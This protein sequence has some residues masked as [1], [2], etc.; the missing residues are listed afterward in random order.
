[1]LRRHHHRA[2]RFTT[3]G[4]FFDTS[5]KTFAMLTP[6]SPSRLPVS[7]R[8][9]IRVALCAC[10]LA[11]FAPPALAVKDGDKVMVI[12]NVDLTDEGRKI[13]RPTPEQP[14]YY[15]P[16]ILGYHEGGKI[17]GGEQPPS[18]QEMLR[19][20]GRA[21]AK[22]G[23]VLQAV[24]PNANQTLPSL[25]LAFE[26]GYLN[27]STLNFGLMDLTTGEGG[28]LAP[29]EIQSKSSLAT[30][31]A[32]FNQAEMVTL[33]AGSA[34]A[35]QLAAAGSTGL[36]Q[37]E[38]DKIRNAATEDRY[39]IIV[40]AFDFAAS[41]KGEQRLLWRARM[42]TERQGVWMSDV[43]AA[44]V[45]VGAPKFGRETG[46]AFADIPITRGTVKLGPMEIKNADVHPAELKPPAE[47][48]P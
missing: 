43:L 48:K 26:W 15:V 24:R 19:Q 45:T 27:P 32:D 8:R 36:S 1:V 25:I 40:S 6:M 12:V 33:V 10:T 31:T 7:F 23:Y 11:V 9:R 29:S 16:V 3:G 47:K 30:G 18:R 42:S 17:I 35:A 44:L 13:P 20:L 5:L 28:T 38:W 37:I 4:A 14:A 46:P 21:L 2:A 41:L 39:F 34:L 22:E